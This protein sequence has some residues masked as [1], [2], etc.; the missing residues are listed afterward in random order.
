M[1]EALDCTTLMCP[2]PIVRISQAVKALN[3]GDTLEVTAT[4]PAFESDIR[5]WCCKM[6]HELLEYRRDGE[7]CVA[8]IRKK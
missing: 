6:N 3:P 8:V 7:V 1:T 2:M 5:A 4:D